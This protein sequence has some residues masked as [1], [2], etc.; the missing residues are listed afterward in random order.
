MIIILPKLIPVNILLFWNLFTQEFQV[1]IRIKLNKANQ[2]DLIYRL[3]KYYLDNINYTFL[4]N[5]NK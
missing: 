4:K 1:I 2:K 5:N 3:Y